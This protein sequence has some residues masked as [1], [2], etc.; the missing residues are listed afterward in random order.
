MGS[1]QHFVFLHQTPE[2][3]LCEGMIP[4][5]RPLSNYFHQGKGAGFFLTPAQG[6][7]RIV[8]INNHHPYPGA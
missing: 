2:Q 1:I 7:S 3:H 4:W 6:N 8:S 5:L